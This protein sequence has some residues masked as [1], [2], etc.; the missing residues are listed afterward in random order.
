MTRK[1]GEYTLKRPSFE[2]EQLFV[3][4]LKEYATKEIVRL[5]TALGAE[6][7]TQLAGQIIDFATGAW[8][9][10]S[11]RCRLAIENELHFKELIWLMCQEYAATNPQAGT[12]IDRDKFQASWQENQ[13]AFLKAYGE[14]TGPT[15]TTPPPAPGASN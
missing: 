8:A 1:V 9:W 3:N 2:V 11:L 7:Q 4:Y 14:L 12:S 13:A 6:F 10:G 5:K 15:P